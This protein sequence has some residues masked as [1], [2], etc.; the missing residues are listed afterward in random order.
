MKYVAPQMKVFDVDLLNAEILAAACSGYCEG[1][2]ASCGT[3]CKK[4]HTSST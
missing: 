1:G 2:F 3:W 4:G